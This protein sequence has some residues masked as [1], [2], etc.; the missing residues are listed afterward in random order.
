MKTSI[1]FV[2]SVVAPSF[3]LLAQVP[4]PPAGPAPAE[5]A[6]REEVGISANDGITISG[7][8]ILVTRNGVSEKLNKEMRLK[9][10][11]R[12]LPDGRIILASGTE[13]SLKANQV[14]TFAGVVRNVPDRAAAA[15]RPAV[16]ETVTVTLGES[17]PAALAAIPDGVAV[18]NGTPYLIRKG[19]ASIIDLKLIPEG[20][21]LMLDGRLAPIPP[22]FTGFPAIP[23]QKG[24]DQ[25][26]RIGEPGT[27][28]N[29][30]S[31]PAV[32]NDRGTSGLLRE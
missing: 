2:A 6:P 3:M 24:T 22:A 31:D 1:L 25:Q 26:T 27:P 29:S 21:I 4:E 32:R 9:N 5:A 23:V 11:T 18:Y 17:D 14:L 30:K 12:V 19:R 20:Q 16:G 13:L 28:R 15:P 10:D 7:K 8:D